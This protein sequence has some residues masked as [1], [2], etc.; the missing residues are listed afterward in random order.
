MAEWYMNAHSDPVLNSVTFAAPGID[1]RDAFDYR[2]DDRLLNFEVDGHP[3]PDLLPHRGQTIHFD[4][5]LV[6]T[7]PFGY[8]S[9]DLYR[10]L[11]EFVVREGIGEELVRSRL[12]DAESRE[13]AIFARTFEDG[14]GLHV[15]SGNDI[16]WTDYELQRLPYIVAGGDGYDDLYGTTTLLGLAKN[17]VL[18]GGN[19]IDTLRGLGGND[20]LD[21]GPENDN[22]IGGV[23]KDTFFFDAALGASNVDRITDFSVVDDTIQLE[24]SVFSGLTTTGPLASAAFWVGSAA[25]DS[26]DRIVYNS[27]SGA[28]YYDADGSGAGAAVHFANLSTRP[29]LTYAQFTVT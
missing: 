5:T 15:G 29:S 21:G 16:G 10:A 26:T 13:L 3:V 27:S 2:A 6:Y 20:L 23:G 7:N 25:H 14:L 24:N 28:L 1:V 11:T 4:T 17:D 9:M 22:L 12:T 8:H 19:G 18:Y